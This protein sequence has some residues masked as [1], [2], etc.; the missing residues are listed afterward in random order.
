MQYTRQ[1]INNGDVSVLNSFDKDIRELK[2]KFLRG[3]CPNLV[4]LNFSDLLITCL[5]YF[6]ISKCYIF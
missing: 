6:E 1:Q 2:E 5:V 3:K 4:S